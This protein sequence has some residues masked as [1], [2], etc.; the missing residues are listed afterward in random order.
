[1]IHA[2]AAEDGDEAGCR[3]AAADIRA[4]AFGERPTIEIL[5]AERAPKA[6]GCLLFFTNFSSWEGK[7]G[8][9]V[10]DLYVRA[11]LRGRGIGRRLM[12]VVAGLALERGYVRVDWQVIE[13]TR[14]RDFYDGLGAVWIDRLLTYRLTGP[15]LA[16]FAAAA[17][18]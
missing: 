17:A 1:M 10:E 8:L 13:Q 2:H 11:N 16:A 9:F 18:P 4:H 15:A 5:L 14:A 12:S 6:V 3:I 7:P